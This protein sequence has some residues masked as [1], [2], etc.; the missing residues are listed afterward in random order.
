MDASINRV[1]SSQL[2]QT[3]TFYHHHRMRS[4]PLATAVCYATCLLE[5]NYNNNN[6]DKPLQPLDLIR[7]VVDTAANMT[8]APVIALSHGGG[9]L[10]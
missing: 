8:V 6:C 7:R 10:S 3:F 4:A 1:V 2:N 9:K 5:N